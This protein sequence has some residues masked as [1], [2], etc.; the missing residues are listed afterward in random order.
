MFKSPCL[1]AVA[2]AVASLSSGVVQ[3]SD[4][5]VCGF[6]SSMQFLEGAPRDRFVILNS[7]DA[8]WHITSA[9]ID[10][11]ASAGRLIFDITA[12]GAGV[13]VFQPFRTEA[14][15]VVP[16]QSPL[17]ED[18]DQIINLQFEAFGPGE[19]YTFS[20]DVDDQL[21]RSELGQIR[22]SGSEMQ[23]AELTLTV[24]Y[25]NHQAHTLSTRFDADSKAM[26]PRADC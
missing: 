17:V 9:R 1:T 10:L 23:G 24:L 7:S 19:T 2:L 13:E 8:A 3:A 12:Q 5:G 6:A 20:I 21:T 14:G 4:T 22:V 26:I 16:V 25:D 15:S 11:S 18:G